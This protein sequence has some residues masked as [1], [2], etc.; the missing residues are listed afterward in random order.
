LAIAAAALVALPTPLSFAQRGGER[1]GQGPRSGFQRSFGQQGGGGQQRSFNQQAG[2]GQQQSFQGGQR[3]FDQQGTAQRNFGGQPERSPIER[4]SYYGSTNR[5]AAPRMPTQQGRQFQQGARQL[6]QGAQPATRAPRT[7]DFVNRNYRDRGNYNFNS[8]APDTNRNWSNSNNWRGNRGFYGWGNNYPWWA[9]FAGPGI[10]YGWGAPYYGYGG[11][12]GGYGN[13][14]AGYGY[15]YGFAYGYGYGSPYAV[16]SGDTIATQPPQTV[17]ADTTS[18]DDYIVQGEQ[19]FRAG[20][21]EMAAR[22]WQ[23]AMVDNPNN[24]AVLALLAQAL[25][26]MGQWPS[27]AGTV[28]AAMQILPEREWGAVVKNYTQLYGNVGDY[29]NQLKVLEKARDSNPEDPAVRFLLGHH[30]GF[31]GYPKQA[32]TELDKVLDLQPR[33]VAAYKLRTLLAKQANLPERAQPAEQLEQT[34]QPAGAES[35]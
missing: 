2:G 35:K 18:S 19:A 26:Q 23:H 34:P 15:P 5:P 14:W 30:F 11:R 10:G 8:H 25:F 1:G 4:R 13:R 29:T 22:H 31:L 28:Q 6:R 24:G 9:W 17:T 7:S 33:D 3:A 16:Y 21:Y 12:W 32:V 27:A 20:Q